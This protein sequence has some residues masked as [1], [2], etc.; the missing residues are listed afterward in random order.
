MEEMN[1]EG[2]SARVKFESAEGN[3]ILTIMSFDDYFFTSFSLVESPPCNVM[4]K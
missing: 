2:D 3:N 4:W 1:I